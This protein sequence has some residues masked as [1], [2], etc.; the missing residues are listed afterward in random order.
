MT[1]FLR[2][3]F[4]G[5]TEDPQ[6]EKEKNDR[7]NFELFKFDGLRAQR[8][9]QM[10]YAIRCF[11]K[12]L[13]ID[14]DFETL[15][16][17]TG[18]LIQL[19]RTDE[20]RPLLEEMEVQE[21]ELPATYL[22]LARVC[23]MTEDYAAMKQQAERAIALDAD[24]PLAYL[25]AAQAEKGA[26]E[27][28][29]AIAHL[30]QAIQKKEDYTDAYLLRAE[31]LAGMQQYADAMKDADAVLAYTPDEENALLLRGRM[32]EALGQVGEAQADFAAVKEL[33]PF[34]EQAYLL[35]GHSLIQSKHLDEAIA[36]LDEAI[37]LNPNCAKAYL[38]RGQA[39]LLKGD[40]DG[41]V[42][43]MKHSLEL[44]PDTET[45]ISGQFKNFNDLYANVPL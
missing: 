20:A 35:L 5:K 41:S 24:N 27:P 7:K 36:C 44:N 17:L 14:R 18:T 22:T 3:L 4:G 31:I 2:H 6:A 32:K 12:A 11:Q 21:P 19:G 26:D 43:D 29:H 23:Y 38:E 1:N 16:Y 13:E 28:F 39:K 45:D 10:D 42:E 40:K 15:G 9:G 37:E 33:N 8:M 25:L 30:T 34:N